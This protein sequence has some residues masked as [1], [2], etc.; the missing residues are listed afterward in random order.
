MCKSKC[1]T[2]DTG[3][4]NLTNIFHKAFKRS[5]KCKKDSQLKQ[6]FP[7][8]G[9]AHIKAARKHVDEIDPRCI[10]L[11]LITRFFSNRFIYIFHLVFLKKIRGSQENQF[12]A[13]LCVPPSTLTEEF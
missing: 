8:S 7:L 10:K 6:L 2:A 13:R 3:R 11:N 5:H 12:V 4:V 9:S 1:N